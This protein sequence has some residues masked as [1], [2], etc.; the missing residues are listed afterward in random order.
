MYS[1]SPNEVLSMPVKRF[2]LFDKNV[3]RIEA[4]ES[5]QTLD[6]MVS[7]RDNDNY[8]DMH[9]RLRQQ[10]GVVVLEAPKLDS[11]GLSGLKNMVQIR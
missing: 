7:S 5:I 8:N 6:L 1:L 11:E 9:R 2:W 10:L 4:T 3:S